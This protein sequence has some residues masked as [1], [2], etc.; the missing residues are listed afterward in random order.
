M[1]RK[2][3]HLFILCALVMLFVS[4]AP[5][6]VFQQEVEV[7][8][9]GWHKDSVGVFKF[10]IANIEQNYHALIQVQVNESY[11]YSN[12]WFFVDAM[13]PSGH[14]ERDTIQGYFST[15]EGNWLGEKVWFKDAYESN[16]AYKLNVRFPEKGIYTFRIA[17]GM[18]DTTLLGIDKVGL[19]LYKVEE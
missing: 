18:R 10:N 8:A 11:T 12:I 16:Q 6:P 2:N 4:C 1:I 15:P 9:S 13:S 5:K 17:Q 7:G 3:N 19:S 14:V